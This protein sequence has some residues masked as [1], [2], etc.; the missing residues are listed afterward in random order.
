MSLKHESKK[1]FINESKHDSKNAIFLTVLS[2]RMGSNTNNESNLK[3]GYY[4][5]TIDLK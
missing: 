3:S 4:Y 1:E 5:D 2:L